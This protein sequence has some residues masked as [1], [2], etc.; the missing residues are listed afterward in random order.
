M[1]TSPSR[2]V[3]LIGI[4]P[5]MKVVDFGAGSG[6]YAVELAHAVGI[7]GHV[8]A[9][10]IQKELLDGVVREAERAGYRNI[11]PVWADLEKVEGTKL[12]SG[13]VDVVL[14]SNLLFQIKNKEALFVEASRILKPDG[15]VIVIDWQD[16]FNNMGPQKGTLVP[17]ETAI[18]LAEKARLV[19]R[20]SFDP[21][22]HHYG[23]V[24]DKNIQ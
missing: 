22:D 13:S 20:E 9:V 3:P 8:Y 5:G 23:L 14:V 24:F 2:T 12:G 1:F 18:E 4:K 21:G 16:S 15:R 6:A 11:T 17:R 10:D 19:F 7:D